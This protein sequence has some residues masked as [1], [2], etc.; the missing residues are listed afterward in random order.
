[1][2]TSALY[3]ALGELIGNK[4][5]YYVVAAD[6][7]DEIALDTYPTIVI[8]NT[9]LF[10]DDGQHWLAWYVLSPQRCEFWDSYGLPFYHYKQVRFPV[11]YI[12]RENCEKIQADDSRFC[13]LYCLNF[14]YERSVGLSYSL[15]LSKYSKNLHCND[16][17]TYD[18][19]K[20][21][22]PHMDLEKIYG[23]W[24]KNQT[25]VS[26]KQNGLC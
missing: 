14:V 2:N 11:K 4:I 9:D 6:T 19:S 3:T 18:W 8:Q 12:V 15:F 17:I 25:C 5:P 16:V 23:T 1:M 24:C 13:G 26:R 7:A 21:M 22:L 20:R 10:K